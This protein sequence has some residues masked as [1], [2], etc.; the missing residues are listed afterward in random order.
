LLTG[1]GF[2]MS[3]FASTLIVSAEAY[4][5]DLRIAV[6]LAS[7]ISVICGYPILKIGATR[8]PAS[9]AADQ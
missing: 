8:L 9:A 3:L 2:T 7:L 6:L 1:I 4:D 5:T